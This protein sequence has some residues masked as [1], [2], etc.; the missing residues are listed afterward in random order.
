MY[1]AFHINLYITHDREKQAKILGLSSAEDILYTWFED[2]YS[3]DHCPKFAIAVDHE[4]ER[5]VWAIRQVWDPTFP[6]NL[7]YSGP[8]AG[9]Y[10]SICLISVSFRGTQNL[11]DA[12]IDAICDEEPFLDGF[13][14]KGILRLVN[15]FTQFYIK[16]NYFA[17]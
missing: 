9:L 7:L 15:N 16:F 5:V 17:I 13:A 14:H 11:N 1:F 4:S 8:W 2:D 6:L 10:R 12:V 3:T